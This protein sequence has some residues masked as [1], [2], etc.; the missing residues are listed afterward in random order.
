MWSPAVLCGDDTMTDLFSIAQPTSD[1][2]LITAVRDG[3]DAAFAELYR[4]HLE[5]A[6]AAARSLTRS[7]ADADDVVA[8]GFTRVLQAIRNGGG[9][10]LAFRPY[11]VTAVRNAY[12]DRMRKDR[13]LDARE[14]VPEVLDLSVLRQSDSHDD[15]ALAAR[16]FA[17]LPERWQLVLWHTEVEGRTPA[18]VG[19]LLG[20]APNAVAALAYRAREGLRQAYLQA[21]LQQPIPAECQEIRPQLGAYVRDGLSMR[22]RRKVDAHLET[23]KHCNELVGDLQEANTTLRAAL[24]PLLLGVPAAKYLAQ[25]HGGTGVAAFAKRQSKSVQATAAA[26][27]AVVVVAAGAFGVNRLS[28]PIAPAGAATPTAVVTTVRPA[29]STRPGNT[30]LPTGVGNANSGVTAS[31]SPFTFPVPASDGSSPA[32]A[33]SAAGGSSTL[34]T[35]STIASGAGSSP[36]VPL[37]PFFPTVTTRPSATTRPTTRA[38]TTTHPRSTSATTTTSTTTT[39]TPAGIVSPTVPGDRT[40]GRNTTPVD[41]DTVAST[42][43]ATTTIAATSAATATTTTS[44]TTAP[45]PQVALSIAAPDSA[46]VGLRTYISI[47]LTNHGNTPF[48]APGIF[49]PAVVVASGTTVTI[50]LP[51]ALTFLGVVPHTDGA[52]W[53][54][55]APSDPTHLVCTPPAVGGNASTQVMLELQVAADAADGSLPLS[56]I[57]QSGDFQAT[58]SGSK[59]IDIVS[60]SSVFPSG[61]NPLFFARVPGGG[62]AVVG[63]SSVTCSVATTSERGDGPACGNARMGSGGESNNRQSNTLQM[64]DVLNTG[65]NSS[66]AMLDLPSGRSVL[67][68]YLAWSGDAATPGAVKLVTPETEHKTYASAAPV[69]AEFTHV[70]DPREST[71]LPTIVSFVPHDHSSDGIYESVADVTALVRAGGA[72]TYT[73]ADIS[74]DTNSLALPDPPGVGGWSLFVVYADPTAPT[75]STVVLLDQYSTLDASSTLDG[76]SAASI[77]IDGMASSSPYQVSLAYFA[78]EG[79]LG[80]LGDSVKI[81]DIALTNAVNPLGNA[82]NSSLLGATDPVY[83]NGFGIDVDQFAPVEVTSGSAAFTTTFTSVGDKV[84]VGLL[85]FV[86]S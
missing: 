73:V 5:S 65:N 7:R 35:D 29:K 66:S 2:E 22:D 50:V 58:A 61:G 52:A 67:R 13:R 76:G 24:I 53:D 46:V 49:R 55:H 70:T 17:S 56:A 83:S 11:L 8:E 84:S 78:N 3:D 54:C 68:A 1:A 4:R 40:G 64:K 69:L 86:I 16:A 27:A 31:I 6:K 85:G 32:D 25:L 28:K 39:T 59:R 18:E 12:Y 14:E 51:S 60:Q 10:Q 33:S 80:R 36:T 9:P 30:R 20:L 38:A 48:V 19:P 44:P 45:L 79:D 81:G 23:C 74:I 62:L 82:F 34:P 26:A 75:S 15:R 42:V 47:G 43:A 21:H 57:V 72:G 63:N 37:S 71:P 41:S 77:A